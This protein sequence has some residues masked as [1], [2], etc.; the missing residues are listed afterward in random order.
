[1]ANL[2]YAVVRTVRRHLIPGFVASLYFSLKYGCVIST[3]AKVQ[4][5][6]E[7][8]FGKGTVVKPFAVIQT[9]TGKVTIGRKCAISSFNHI[10]AAD[11]D[12]LIGDHV[13]LGSNVVIVAATR[14]FGD[15]DVLIVD[16]GYSNK[17][18]RIGDDVLIGAGAIVLDGCTI[19]EGAV[20]GAGSVVTRDIPS[21]SIVAG[22][23]AVVIGKRG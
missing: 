11:K 2:R 12:I 5:V 10:S 7:I 22:V 13:R 3:Q 1:M 20:V 23:P 14:N 8:T 4:L 16:Q 15:R 19:G 6:G 18:I 21:Y 9:N 17:G